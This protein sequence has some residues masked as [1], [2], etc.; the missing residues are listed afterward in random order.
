MCPSV[1]R[2]GNGIGR[3]IITH[4]LDI[5]FKVLVVR[6]CQLIVGPIQGGGIKWVSKVDPLLTRGHAV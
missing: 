6:K 3:I 2:S 4:R 1:F 5:S